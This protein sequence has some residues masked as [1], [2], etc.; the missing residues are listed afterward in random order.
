MFHFLIISK[1][2]FKI[3]RINKEC[4]YKGRNQEDVQENVRYNEYIFNHKKYFK[5]KS[6]FI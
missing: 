5:I 1:K 6:K 3:N 4:K 2:T